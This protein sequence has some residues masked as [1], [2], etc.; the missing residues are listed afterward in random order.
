MR[1]DGR[2]NCWRL[3]I[4]LFKRLIT[5]LWHC[6]NGGILDD[7]PLVGNTIPRALVLLINDGFWHF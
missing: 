3:F 1:V 2:F 4:T 7:E 5:T 6:V